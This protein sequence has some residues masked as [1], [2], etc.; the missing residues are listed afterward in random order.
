MSGVW[1][2]FE[3]SETSEKMSKREREDKED[4]GGV[5]KRKKMDGELK[6]LVEK[7]KETKDWNE[8]CLLYTS[9]SPRD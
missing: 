8:V 1:S 4:V 2:R 6:V 3:K 9:P 5:E 7:A